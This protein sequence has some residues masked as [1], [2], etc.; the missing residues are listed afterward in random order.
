MALPGHAGRPQRPGA[1]DRLHP[2]RSDSALVVAVGSN[3]SRAVLQ[4]KFDRFGVRSAARFV[5][6]RVGGL[7]VGHSAHVSAPGFIPAAPIADPAAE[8]DLVASVLDADGLAALDATEPNYVRHRLAAEDFPIELEGGLRPR[9]FF[10]Y[11]SRHGVL[12]D[13]DRPLELTPQESLLHR[14]A[15]D[16]RGFAGLA[17]GRPRAVMRRFAGNPELRDAIRRLF[18]QTG[19]VQAAGSLGP[20]VNRQDSEI[21]VGP[22]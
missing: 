8:S 15:R 6:A 19:W 18:G 12:A 5:R 21:G 7:R 11:V 3:A 10:V 22:G 2:D 14:L 1:A 20:T 17:P 4:R 13:G 9:S 16:C